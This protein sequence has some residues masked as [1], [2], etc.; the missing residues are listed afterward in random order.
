MDLIAN[1][2]NDP[3][4]IILDLELVVILKRL[5][6]VNLVSDQERDPTE[7]SMT[8]P[9]SVVDS[10][11]WPYPV[12]EMISP[13]HL[14]LL[15]NLPCSWSLLASLAR[16]FFSDSGSWKNS[17]PTSFSCPI[18][19]GGIPWLTTWK[20]PH[21]SLAFTTARATR[22][23]FGLLRSTTGISSKAEIVSTVSFH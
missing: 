16:A 23:S 1:D 10:R 3:G 4:V 7:I 14:N 11:R 21:S 12:E 18:S 8:R 13:S 19:S 6:S 15:R 5:K 9:E 17:V 2:D 22:S 20:M